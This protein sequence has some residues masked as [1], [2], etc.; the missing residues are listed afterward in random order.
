MTKGGDRYLRE[1]LKIGSS[2]VEEINRFLLDP[3]S[4]II[5]AMLQVVAKYGTPEELS[6]IHI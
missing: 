6:L 4:S 3:D 5:N 1:R 2:V